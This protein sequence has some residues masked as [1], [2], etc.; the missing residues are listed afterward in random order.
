MSGFCISFKGFSIVNE[1]E[2]DVIL[3]FSY[4]FCGPGDVGNLICGSSAFSK[5]YLYICKLLDH[6][7][8]KSSL[9][10][11]EYDVSSM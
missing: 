7:L 4:V 11:F 10:D 8:L 3:K 2:V 6:I 5:S 9:E 1:T